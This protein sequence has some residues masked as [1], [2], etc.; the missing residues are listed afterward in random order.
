MC[1]IAGFF[2]KKPVSE[3]KIKLTL[4]TMKNRGP[5]HRAFETIRSGENHIALL[6]SRLSI[7]DL[8]PRSNQPFTIGECTLV[9]NGEI[10]NYV[11]LKKQLEA[12]GVQFRTESDTEVLLQL[13]LQHGP[14]FVEQM[15]G[16]WSFALFDRRNGELLLSR[17]RF[18]EKPLY[19]VETPEG[20][21][22]GSEVKFLKALSG[23]KFNVNEQQLL[24]YLVNGYKALYKQPETYFKEVKEVGYATSMTIGRDLS[25]RNN[26]YWKPAYKPRKMSLA[27]AIEGTRHH[28]FE[29]VRIRLRADVP[30]AFC[31]SGGVDSSA[32]TS[33]AAKKFGCDVATFSI[34]DT[35]ERYNEYDNIKATVDDL[36]CKNHVIH[37]K[38]EPT[39]DRLEQII[40]YHD[41]PIAT[42][43]YYIH[44]YLS[45]AIAKHGSR[46]VFSGTAADELF[47][48]YYDHFNLH[49]YEVRNH[50]EYKKYLK[51]WEEHT[52]RWVR[53]PYLKNP[54]LYFKNPKFNDHIYLNNDEFAAFLTVDFKEKYF[55]ENYTDS[56]LRNRMMN[57]LFHEVTPVVLHEDDLNSMKFSLENRSPYLDSRLFEFAYSIPPEHLM[58]EGF[59]KYLLRE[60]VKGV[61]NDKVRL[62]RQKKGFNASITSVLDFNSTRVRERLLDDGPVFRFFKRERV[63]ELLSQPVFSDSYNKFFFNFI[64]TKLFL[65]QHG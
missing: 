4:D 2:G 31:L 14:K 16:M 22:F 11:E 36:G 48:G 32:L 64:N 53:N 10:Y 56:P 3:E 44:S 41:A 60:S 46:V 59:A 45:E 47:T 58:Q 55:D 50:P 28:L 18:G 43:T 39:L 5:D 57:E 34:I 20:I 52:G 51:D 65:E 12:K 30:L 40:G 15:E 8:D 21:Y 61:L 29:S 49:L 38:P 33:I 54:E 42:V 24:R 27:E 35:D 19:F 9:F 62:D 13:Y 17:D 37:L 23:R 7:I 6:H 26:R 1:G 63:E 25:L